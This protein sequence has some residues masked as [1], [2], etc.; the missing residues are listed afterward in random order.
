MT[1]RPTV[2]Q[3]GGL[4]RILKVLREINKSGSNN[5]WQKK[6]V[7]AVVRFG[8]CTRLDIRLYMKH[9]IK[10]C[11][12]LSNWKL[13]KKGIS[14]DYSDVLDILNLDLMQKAAEAIEQF[15]PSVAKKEIPLAV[16]EGSHAGIDMRADEA[17]GS[18]EHFE[19]EGNTLKGG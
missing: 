9:V 15:D 18:V 4:P 14:L 8:T 11:E 7:L 17:P 1:M 5:E 19:E 3:R 2:P 6:V 12:T 16:D 13:T 10:G